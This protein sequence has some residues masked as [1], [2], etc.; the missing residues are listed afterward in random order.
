[1]TNPADPGF[2]GP[3][4]AEFTY[5]AIHSNLVDFLE[6]APPQMVDYIFE[7]LGGRVTFGA[8]IRAIADGRARLD[9]FLD[10]E[11]EKPVLELSVMAGDADPFQL[12]QLDGPSV[13]VDPVYLMREQRY[14]LDQAIAAITGGDL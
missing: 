1:M 3:A 4:L 9:V 7:Q 5:R 10:D 14:R 12:L 13:G 11:T 8:L 6:D 2:P